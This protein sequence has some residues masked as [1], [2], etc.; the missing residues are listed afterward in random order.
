M[1]Y[2]QASLHGLLNPS[3][4]EARI[5][6]YYKSHLNVDG[7]RQSYNYYKS[8]REVGASRLDNTV[9]AGAI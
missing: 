7:R 2:H 5:Y 8:Q 4:L 3:S 1:N 9:G 6:N